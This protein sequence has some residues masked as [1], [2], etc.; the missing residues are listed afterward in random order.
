VIIPVDKD[1]VKQCNNEEG[2]KDQHRQESNADGEAM[3]PASTLEAK[4]DNTSLQE[5]ISITSSI[6]DKTHIAS[7]G[8]ECALPITQTK[9]DDKN[10][11]QKKPTLKPSI[12]HQKVAPQ[13]IAAAPID[14]TLSAMPIIQDPRS[15]MA[16]DIHKALMF[17]FT[18][19]EAFCKVLRRK[20]VSEKLFYRKIASA[21]IQLHIPTHELI[22]RLR[23]VQDNSIAMEEIVSHILLA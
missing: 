3:P 13:V 18:L 12:T 23:M 9:S 20:G 19:R 10:A 17:D 22:D 4:S 6:K 11:P 14:M 8:V 2:N 15:W 21:A 7:T 1:T 16:S 5:N